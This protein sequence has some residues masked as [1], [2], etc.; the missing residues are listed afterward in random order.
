MLELD[1]VGA[2]PTTWDS[3]QETFPDRSV[4]E[5]LVSVASTCAQERAVTDQAG[6]FS[7]ADVLH[8]SADVCLRV[9]EVARPGD[10]VA[11]LR[12]HN[13]GA[14]MTAVGV[15]ASGSPL[16]VLDP[17]APEGRLRQ[18]VEAGGVHAI[19]T[20]AAHAALARRLGRPVV[21]LGAPRSGLPAAPD[22]LARAANV[23][24]ASGATLTDACVVVFTSGT[25]GGPKAVVSDHGAILHE[26]FTNS[27]GTDCY[28][29]GEQVGQLLPMAFAA[30]LGITFTALLAGACQHLFDPRSRSISSLPAWLAE[31][32]VRVLTAGPAIMRGLLNVLPPGDRLP[33]LRTVTLGG[34]TVYGRDVQR[35]LD[36]VGPECALRNRYGSTETWLATE[37]V[38]RQGDVF[39][40]AAPV[41]TAVPGVRIE[42]LDDTGERRASGT[43]RVVITSHWLSTG[44]RGNDVATARVFLDNPDGTR[45]FVTND[46]G[47]LVDG[48]LTLLGRT[49]HSV[50]IRG[51]MVEPGEIDAA[52]HRLPGV[53]EAVVVG[54]TSPVTGLPALAAYVVTTEG[55]WSAGDV[56][57]HVR[58][59]LP[60]YM[61]PEHVVF[62]DALPRNERGKLDR[63]ALPPP[64]DGPTL[65][66][67]R[68]HWEQAVV[69]AFS[70]VL[71]RR[72]GR[73][74][75]FVAAGGDS[76]AAEELFAVVHAELG[77][78]EGLLTTGLL[79]T[80]PTP[81][82]FADAVRQGRLAPVGA[83]P[84]RSG[85]SEPALFLVAGAGG[86]AYTFAP[87]VHCLDQGYPV[88]AMQDRGLEGKGWPD[89]TLRRRARRHLRELR[90]V[91]P[92]G[93][94]RLGG[95]SMGGLI[96]LEMAAILVRE[97][98]TVEVVVVIDSY[99]P[100][101][102]VMP[103]AHEGGLANALRALRNLVAPHLVA[104]RGRNLRFYRQGV[105]VQRFHRTSP[106][107]GRTVVVVAED[108]NEAANRLAWD[109][110]LLGDWSLVRIPG[111]HLSILRAP[112][113][114]ALAAVVDSA[115]RSR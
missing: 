20:D 9:R 95:H 53:R 58:A 84:L 72:V 85:G 51:S 52:L 93:P 87:L 36:A 107:S 41:G 61:V 43:G 55:T 13:A 8:G 101:P 24:L 35:L 105:V 100:D 80:S 76:L 5:R 108:D 32:D 83:L 2:L 57:A 59:H 4:T 64:S 68:D 112:R 1:R 106:Y 11:V 81:A 21:V 96:A 23:L 90:A 16:V 62:L 98:E 75:D 40:G 48:R 79:A 69:D 6:Q 15:V 63:A 92:S 94:Y 12:G 115:V 78:S 47:R 103:P 3:V 86:Y 34:E 19:V 10:L 99:P 42:V 25:T 29:R 114:A 50:K 54:I 46:V 74:D 104:G 110:H 66:D 91:Q 89:Y 82:A 7:F 49:D 71:G 65:Q 37:Q 77:V 33:G 28:G 109:Q 88:Y 17:S 111:D 60:G 97:G 31:H 30:G 56:R 27:I 67:G 73:S 14:V 18:L 44:Y 26:A 39:D 38:I 70:R 45:S 22:E 102:A 113:V